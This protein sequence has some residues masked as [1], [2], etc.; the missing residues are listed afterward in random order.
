MS[1][2]EVF[3]VGDPEQVRPRKKKWELAQEQKVEEFRSVAT[4]RH[5]RAVLWRILEECGV[6]RASFEG[7]VNH[8][9]WREGKRKVGQE[10]YI[11]FDDLGVEGD[12]L[13]SLMQLEA[14]ALERKNASNE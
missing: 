2:T 8:T 12:K 1:E 11:M 13:F 10:I 6:H 5:G 7:D 4:T 9:L 3:D 14:K